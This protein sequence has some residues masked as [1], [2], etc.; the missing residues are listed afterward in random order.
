MTNTLKPGYIVNGPFLPEPVEVIAAV[1]IGDSTKLVGKGL[2]TGLAH[3]PIL[4]P[5]QVAQ[6]VVSQ[7]R[8]PFDADAR[9][10][11][12]G[13]EAQR[14]GLAYE[15]DP[16]LPPQQNLWAISGSGNAPS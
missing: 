3:D 1:S 11:R 6:L 7:E 4:S 16:F 5:D 8:E 14:L 12:L 15:Y 9:L 10:F 2:K 13:V